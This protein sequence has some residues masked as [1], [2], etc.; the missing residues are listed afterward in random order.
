LKY[1]RPVAEWVMGALGLRVVVVL[2]V[3]ALGMLEIL[4]SMLDAGC[5]PLHNL[6]R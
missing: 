6:F 2:V 3:M 4:P 5:N 1:E